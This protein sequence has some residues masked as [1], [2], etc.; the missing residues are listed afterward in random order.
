M[1]KVMVGSRMSRS[2]SVTDSKASSLCY[3]DMGQTYST[4]YGQTY[5]TDYAATIGTYVTAI[6]LHIG[7]DLTARPASRRSTTEAN[8]LLPPPLPTGTYVR[9]HI[10]LYQLTLPISACTRYQPS[11]PISMHALNVV[12]RHATAYGLFDVT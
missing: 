5:S 8:M 10:I 6:C 7:P 4:K 2:I 3:M 11:M 9:T 12:Y 1:M